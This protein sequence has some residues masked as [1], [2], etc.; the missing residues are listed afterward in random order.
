MGYSKNEAKDGSISSIKGTVPTGGRH[1]VLRRVNAN[2]PYISILWYHD[3]NST[4]VLNNL[5]KELK[6]FYVG[7]SDN[8]RVYNV[9]DGKT[10]YRFII[11]GSDAWG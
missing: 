11:M 6:P 8:H 3:G 7:L 4:T 5:L 10:T 9:I 2:I 1:S